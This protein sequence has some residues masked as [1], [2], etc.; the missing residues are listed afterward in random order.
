MDRFLIDLL[1]SIKP[2]EMPDLP[3]LWKTFG[4]RC[5]RRGLVGFGG[6]CARVCDRAV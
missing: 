2:C 6:S 5:R 4:A 1:Q 3:D